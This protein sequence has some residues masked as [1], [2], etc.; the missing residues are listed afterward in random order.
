MVNTANNKKIPLKSEK[1]T[2]DKA[3]NIQLGMSNGIHGIS[4]TPVIV[5]NFI[6]RK[7]INTEKRSIS[8]KRRKFSGVSF[9]ILSDFSTDFLLLALIAYFF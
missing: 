2:E 3:K 6:G 8:D 5:A 7:K 1:K 9:P 4:G